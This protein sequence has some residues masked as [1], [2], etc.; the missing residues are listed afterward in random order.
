MAKPRVRKSYE[1]KYLSLRKVSCRD[2]SEVGIS[3]E[4]VANTSCSAALADSLLGLNSIVL[5]MGVLSG[6]G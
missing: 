2:V 3:P 6:E 5:C 4:T 1:T